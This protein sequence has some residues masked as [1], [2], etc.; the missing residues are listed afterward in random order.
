[1]IDDERNILYSRTHESKIQVFDLG[2][3]GDSAPKKVAEERN[4]GEHRDGRSGRRSTSRAHKSP[5]V[6]ICLRP[7]LQTCI[8]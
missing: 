2:K 3:A 7:S 5:I 6:L 4:L 1:M 8:W